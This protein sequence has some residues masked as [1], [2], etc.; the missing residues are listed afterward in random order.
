MIEEFTS[1]VEL[2][3]IRDGNYTIYVFKDLDKKEYIMCTKLPNWNTPNLN[4]GDIGFVKYQIVKA[5]DE[6]YD[7]IREITTI[8][9]YS[10]IYFI[11]FI[12]KSDI[13]K[14]KEIIL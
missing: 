12:N 9:K 4:I 10:N 1:E 3:A 11:N 8:Y 14:N 13:V 7:P 5:G 6:Y 2:L